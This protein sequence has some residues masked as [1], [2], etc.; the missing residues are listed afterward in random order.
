MQP[1]HFLGIFKEETKPRNMKNILLIFTLALFTVQAKAQETE[2]RSLSDF[3]SVSSSQ[4]IRVT[5]KKGDQPKVEVTTSGELDDVITEVTSGDLVI[6]MASNKTFRNVE[7]DVIV[8]FQD[9]SD[10]K[11][12]SSSRMI[13]DE[14]IVANDFDIK[15]SSSAR[16][17]L[18]VKAADLE[19]K[20]SSSASITLEAEA[21]EL[22]VEVSSSGKV[23]LSG[24]SE[25]VEAKASSSGRL[26]GADFT[27]QS[28]DLVASSSGRIELNVEK[29]LTAR[30]SSSGK[31]SYG[32]NPSFVDSNTSSGGR[33]SKK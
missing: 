31:I 18:R 2:T 29:E 16:I 12:S 15:A 7:V 4:S 22:E 17:N 26:S 27:C 28:A 11:A 8:Y 21:K 30:A 32:A 25:T 24:N 14:L 33:V 5:L 3:T 23:D 9:L 19:V 1:F 10:V 6:E 13:S 20:A